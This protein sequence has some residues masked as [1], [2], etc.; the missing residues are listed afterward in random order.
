MW[1]AVAG[2]LT[3]IPMTGF[4]V[5]MSLAATKVAYGTAFVTLQV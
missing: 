4:W 3:H 1:V 2:P 5:L